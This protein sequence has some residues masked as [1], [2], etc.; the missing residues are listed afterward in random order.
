MTR[1][2]NRSP[3]HLGVWPGPVVALTMQV[4]RL[5]RQLRLAQHRGDRDEVA[6]LRAQLSGMLAALHRAKCEV[7]GDDHDA[8]P[9]T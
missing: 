1:W 8:P 4:V 2:S 3:Q 9:A 6:V 5:E 7:M